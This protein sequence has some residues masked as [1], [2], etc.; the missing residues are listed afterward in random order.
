MSNNYKVI[1]NE[2][3]EFPLTKDDT[4]NLDAIE[5]IN[6]KQHILQNN[7]PFYAEIVKSDFDSKKYV[8]KVNNNTY[9]VT[10]QNELDML[11][12]KM[13]FEIGKSKQVNDIKAPM[14]GLILEVA[15]KEG[16]EVQEN[17]LLIVL[18]AMKMENSIS[19]PREGII[20]TIKIC[21]GDA[22]DKGSLLIEFEA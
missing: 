4:S 19:S 14:P 11:I 17:D 18:E 2:T 10:I 9:Q 5:T 8:I 22:V 20:K 15:V 3:N 6:S 12:A 16:Q 1:V 7:I 13:G 21:K